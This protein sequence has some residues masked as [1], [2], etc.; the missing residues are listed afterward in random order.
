M[1]TIN[2]N[3]NFQKA[4]TLVNTLPK[5][6]KPIAAFVALQEST[7][8]LANVRFVQD[9]VTNLVPKATFS[10]SKAD[11]AEASILEIS[12]SI[13]VYYMPAL[14]GEKIFRKAF[15]KNLLENEKKLV[16]MSTRE[17]LKNK[18]L[19]NNGAFKK[20]MAV[21]A[22]I[23]LAGLCIPLTQFCLNYVTNLFTL[24]V[25]KQ[26]KFENVVN[27]NK[28]KQESK[29]D[30]NRVKDSA[31]K[32]IK[33]A[34]IAGIAS[35]GLGALL[36]FK[37]QKSKLLQ[38]LS[39]LVLMP[40]KKL[41]KNEKLQKG[42]DNYFSLE[43]ANNNGKLALNKGQITSCVFIAGLGYFGAAKDRGKQNFLEV[44][45]RYPLVGFYVI[46][47]GSLLDKGFKKLLSKDNKY[48]DLIDKNFEVP[49]LD[50]LP[51]LA[52]K[53]ATKNNTTVE[54][55]FKRLFKGKS[56]ITGIPFLFGLLF[57]GFFVAGMTRFWTAFRYKKSEQAKQIENS[58]NFNY[59]NPVFK[60]FFK[61][62]V[63]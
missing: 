10:R 13:L 50:E 55:E 26:V 28:T 41:F 27:L 7:G 11:L 37:G 57:M 63:S 14:L 17:L 42:F 32:N 43:F 31:E 52:K 2:K 9:T 56:I 21:K 19:A 30:Q 24:K 16:A 59:D 47:G 39:E 45:S 54:S 40:G 1:S 20:I 51:E 25:F 60:N 12:E 23:S 15:S 38:S 34:A 44:L 58:Y 3:I 53:L 8:G 62:S 35:I 36:A 5:V 22:A 48:K 18:E 4:G 6:C 29:E 61:K 49:K 33:N 46:T